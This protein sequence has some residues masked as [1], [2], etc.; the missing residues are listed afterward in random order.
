MDIAGVTQTAQVLPGSQPQPADQQVMAPEQ[1]Q[2]TGA[3]SINLSA[4]VS[5]KVLDMA[6]NQFEEAANQL[7]SQMAAMTGV[8]QNVDVT[9]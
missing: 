7:I 6:Q 3:D 8:G 2:P 1:S 9:T 4:Q 5:A